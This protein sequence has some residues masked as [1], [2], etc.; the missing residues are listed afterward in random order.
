M[1]RGLLKSVA[2]YYINVTS[3]YIAYKF[4][5]MGLSV[6]MQ[7]GHHMSFS[8]SL[9][10]QRVSPFPMEVYAFAQQLRAIPVCYVTTPSE[11]HKQDRRFPSVPLS[12]SSLAPMTLAIAP[13]PM[14]R[15]FKAFSLSVRHKQHICWVGFPTAIPSSFLQ[16]LLSATIQNNTSSIH[17]AKQ[18]AKTRSVVACSQ[19]TS[20]K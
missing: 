11:D 17:H 6:E 15:A 5:V 9:L 14:L 4:Q 12:I 3:P 2:H 10:T 19:F 16:H 18:K 7:S 20:P 8:S 13:R 1:L